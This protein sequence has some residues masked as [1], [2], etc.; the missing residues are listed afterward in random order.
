MMA[1][2]NKLRFCSYNVKNYDPVKYNIVKELFNECDFLLLQ[3]TWLVENEFIRRFKNDFSNSVCVSASKMDLDGIKGGRP[4]GGL[5]ICYHSSLKCQVEYIATVSKNICALKVNICDISLML[6]NVYM[7]S[8]DKLEALDEY[9]CILQE[10]SNICIQSPTQHLILGGDWNANVNRLDS[11]SKLFKEFISGESLINAL[12][13]SIANVPYTYENTRVSPSTFSTIDHFLI[14][15]NLSNA[16]IGYDTIFSHNDF[17]DHFPIMLT[18]NIN[19]EFFKFTKKEHKPS[20]A[21]HKCSEANIESYKE[22][23]D[24]ELLQVNP[25]HDGLTCK[26]Y[27]CEIHKKY[28]QDLYDKI[29]NVCC[30]ASLKCL[31]HTSA[32]SARKTIPGWNQHVKEHA[33]NSKTWHDIWVQSGR[34]RHGDIANMKRKSRLKYHYAIRYVTKENLKIRNC[35][36]G[37]AISKNNDRVLWDEVRKMTKTSHDLPN[38]MDGITGIEDIAEIFCNKYKTLYNSVGYDIQ[39]MTKLE[40]EIDKLVKVESNKPLKSLSVKQIKDAIGSLKLGK[41]EE[42]GL[43]SNHFVYGSDRLIV[44]LTLLFNSMI[45]HGIAPDN[46]LIGTMIP[47][48]KNRRESCQN[49]DN[50]RALTIGTGLSKLLETV[51]SNSQ[52]DVL[53]TSELQF[54]FK[55]DSSTTLCSF[56]VLETIAYYKNRGSNVHMLLLDASKA[57]DRV[58]YTKLFDKLIKKGMCPLIVRLLLNMY[59][60][61]KLQVK[62]NSCISP[63]FNVTNGVR[64]GGILS[65]LFFSVYIDDLLVKLKNNAVGCH[66]GNHY[67]GALGYADDLILLC[68]SVSGMRKMIKVCEDYA[69]DHSILFNGKKSKYLVFGNY[70][71]DPKLVVNNEIVPRSDNA[72]HLGHL[73]HTK[74]TNNALVEDAIKS[75]H[76][77]F[78]GFISKFGDCNVSTKNRLFHQYCRSMYGSQIWQLTSEGTKNMCTQWRKAHRRVLTTPYRTHCD[79]IPLVAD[80]VPIECFLDCK[81]LSFYKSIIKSKNKMVK[82]IADINTYDYNSTLGKNMIHL[83]HKYGLKVED[84]V[85]LSKKE[86]KSQCYQKWLSEVNEQHVTNAYI[87]RELLMVKEDRLQIIFPNGDV[88]LSYEAYDLI[89]NFLCIS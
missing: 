79:I 49:S 14:S 23:I 42:N 73:L 37:E 15:P 67:I 27:K 88:G 61:Q 50:Y 86:I 69:N 74:D 25:Q 56:M 66:V 5:G 45:V 71:Y 34:P 8:S 46:L 85:S 22:E 40:T 84:I 11:R 89:I 9:T 26:N 33:E 83:I 28:I 63:R 87:I 51:I 24:I 70:A 62:W 59:T 54:G 6:I 58:N 60:N 16:V 57:F 44:I 82:Y 17:S 20:V 41:K 29:I 36:M 75:F 2:N 77:S 47:L 13:L 21:W 18:L 4:Y 55:S 64:Q 7:P 68:P 76:Q 19:I 52:T 31:P 81:F 48:I 39:D 38:M 80:N 53:K 10:V 1:T 78:H 32:S 30:Q 43:F 35:K 72:I 65:P 12:T 3:E